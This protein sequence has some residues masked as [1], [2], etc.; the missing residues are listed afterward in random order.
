[1][2]KNMLFF[3]GEKNFKPIK[4]FETKKIGKTGEK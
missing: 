1:M 2:L 3:H 4:N